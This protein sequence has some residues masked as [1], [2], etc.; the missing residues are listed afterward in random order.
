MNEETEQTIEPAKSF[1]FKDLQ[2]R[3]QKAGLPALEGLAEIAYKEVMDWA[4]YGCVNHENALVKSLGTAA[5]ATLR[6]L[7]QEQIDKIDGQP[8]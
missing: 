5:V 4:E 3:L 2:D 7:G 8:G 1:D 6:P